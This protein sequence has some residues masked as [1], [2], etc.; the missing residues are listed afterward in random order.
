MIAQDIFTI[1]MFEIASIM[2]A[3]TEVSLRQLEGSSLSNTILRNPNTVSSELSNPHIDALAR[4]L[5]DAGLAT[6]EAALMV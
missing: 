4:I 6:E 5:C 3:L 1:F 2:D